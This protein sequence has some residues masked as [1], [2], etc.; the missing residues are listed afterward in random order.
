MLQRWMQL[1]GALVTRWKELGWGRRPTHSPDTEGSREKLKTRKHVSTLVFPSARSSDR[2]TDT[3]A[4]AFLWDMLRQ[5]QSWV[6]KSHCFPLVAHGAAPGCSN[7]TLPLHTVHFSGGFSNWHIPPCGAAWKST[8]PQSGEERGDSRTP[9]KRQVSAP[10]AFKRGVAVRSETSVCPCGASPALPRVPT[11]QGLSACFAGRGAGTPRFPRSS[12]VWRCWRVCPPL[13]RR[14]VP[15]SSGL[16]LDR[17]GLPVYLNWR[18]YRAQDRNE[19]RL[20][21]SWVT[22]ATRGLPAPLCCE[23]GPCDLCSHLHSFL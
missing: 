13:N 6:T 18:G 19:E 9:G 2:Q 15:G 12:R 10:S 16:L 1:A 22:A 21:G 7:P 17:R 20:P 8:R 3:Q 14:L 4:S 11:H 23:Q 5:P